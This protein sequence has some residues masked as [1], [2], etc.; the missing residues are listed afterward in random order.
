MQGLPPAWQRVVHLA[1]A[2]PG[3]WDSDRMAAECCTTRRT[4]ER[5]MRRVGLPGPA[6]LLEWRAKVVAKVS[7]IRIARMRTEAER[8]QSDDRCTRWCHGG[9]SSVEAGNLSVTIT[10][11]FWPTTGRCI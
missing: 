2:N 1:L 11:V 9:T 5:R 7:R 3:D 8:V 10:T 4:L 6:A